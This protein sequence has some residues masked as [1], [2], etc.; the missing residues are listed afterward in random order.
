MAAM[1]TGLPSAADHSVLPFPQLVPSNTC[2]R[3]DVCCR[4]PDPD[5]PL[6]PYF[7]GREIAGAIGSGRLG[8]RQFPSLAGGQVSLVPDKRGEGYVCPAFDEGTAHCR[9]Y[10]QRPIDC[11]LYPLALMWDDAHD[12]VV[13]GWDSKCPF[14]QD[15][16]PQTIRAHAD[17]MLARLNEPDVQRAISDHPRLIG[18]FQPDVTVLNR[19]PELTGAL[20]ARWG[21]VPV[22]RLTLDDLPRMQAAL[23]RSGL[24]DSRSLAA[25]STVYHY[26]GNGFMTYW[27]AELQ[28]AFCLF[29]ES[30]DGWFMPLPPLT[31]G[32]IVEPLAE[33]F[34]LMR[35][36]NGSSSAARVEN[37][38]T[39]V[40]SMVKSHGYRLVPKDPD[41][42]YRAAELAALAGDRYKSQ[43]ALCNKIERMGG[44][45]VEPYGLSDRRDCRALLSDWQRQKQDGELEPFGRLLLEDAPSA[46]EIVWT[47][48]EALGL[49]GLVVRLG[50]RI[51]AYTFGFWISSST[52]A[53]L[54]EIADRTVP[55]LAQYLFRETCRRAS[56]QG[57]EFINTMDD[58]GLAGLRASKQ[59]YH[60]VA[61]IESYIL[62]EAAS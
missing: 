17:L 49:S 38:S 33:A 52:W 45:A 36:R 62:S 15:Q 23:H 57:A 16:V 26:M 21:T 3:C 47:H 50:G 29:I 37:A 22:H 18:R 24:C 1:T 27:W 6:R 19:L 32:P 35:R 11:Q 30:P 48:A 4:F 58:A 43:R 10:Q 25:Y 7:T 60:P 8:E 55:G 13:L 61:T 54:V 20:Q 53:V 12:Q 56:D 44:A 5:S 14:L 46:H 51:R 28:G 9:I 2:L 34:R 59:A 42:L 39:A 41:Y 40:A 31:D